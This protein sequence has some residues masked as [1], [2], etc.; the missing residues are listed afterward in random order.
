MK[1]KAMGLPIKV[2]MGLVLLLTFLA[3]A[4]YITIGLTRADLIGKIIP[5]LSIMF[6][7]YV[8]I[9]IST[10]ITAGILSFK[11]FKRANL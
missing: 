3:G 11:M 1:K 7:A 9:G 2:L 6:A 10:L 8:F 5:S 4:N